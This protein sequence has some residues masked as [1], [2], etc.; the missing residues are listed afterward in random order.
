M[1]IRNAPPV[2][3]AK[4]DDDAIHIERT[5]YALQTTLFHRNKPG[6]MFMLILATVALIAFFDVLDTYGWSAFSDESSFI[7]VSIIPLTLLFLP[8]IASAYAKTKTDPVAWTF[9]RSPE[10][11]TFQQRSLWTLFSKKPRSLRQPASVDLGSTE[12]GASF[13]TLLN[14]NLFENDVRTHGL[15]IYDSLLEAHDVCLTFSEHISH[16]SYESGLISPLTANGSTSETPDSMSSPEYPTSFDL[17]PYPKGPAIISALFGSLFVV[18]LVVL[19]IVLL[20]KL[21]TNLNAFLSPLLDQSFL[22][23]FLIIATVGGTLFAAL[24][25]LTIYTFKDLFR[26]YGARTLLID[27]DGLILIESGPTSVRQQARIPFEDLNKLFINRGALG[28]WLGMLEDNHLVVRWNTASFAVFGDG[29]SIEELAT[30]KSAIEQK[31]ATWS[32]AASLNTPG[33]PSLSPAPA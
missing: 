22:L 32:H 10:P 21:T 1:Y 15:A 28:S 17:P 20:Y 14:I 27:D 30:L 3:Q 6:F 11:A 12:Q 31:R 26:A 18:P 7:Y 25:L 8:I 2:L 5:P 33:T 29:L 13:R 4:L 9:K 23:P 24:Y 16:I 19:A